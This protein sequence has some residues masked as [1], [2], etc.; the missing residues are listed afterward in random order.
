MLETVRSQENGWQEPDESR[1]SR[2]CLWGTGGEIPPVYPTQR[3]RS[4]QFYWDTIIV[5]VLLPE[6]GL[7]LLSAP[8]SCTG[9][10]GL[11][12]RSRLAGAGFKTPQ[13]AVVKSHGGER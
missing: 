9:D 1:G 8:R 10:E 7:H 11:A 5:S 6:L 12:P 2:P 13:A 3:G 4:P